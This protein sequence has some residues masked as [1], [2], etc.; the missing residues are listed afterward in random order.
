MT[1]TKVP[2]GTGPRPPKDV[3]IEGLLGRAAPAR[4]SPPRTPLPKPP[5]AKPAGAPLA[6]QRSRAAGA[7]HAAITGNLDSYA[8]Y[9]DWAARV[10]DAWE[11]APRPA[12]GP[13]R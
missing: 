7:R 13:K 4:R 10:R 5:L 6:P 11:P 2:G 8:N 12:P 1:D 3:E 9:R